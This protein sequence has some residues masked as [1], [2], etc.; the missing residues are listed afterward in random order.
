[1]L[2]TLINWDRELFLW[3]NGQGHP[4]LDDVML[5]LSA[6]LVWAPL[7]LGL[8]YLLY[9][10]YGWS[11]WKPLVAVLVAV[12]LADQITSGFMKPYFE[13]FRPCKD[14]TL[15]GLVINVGKCGAKYG[16]ASSHAANTFALALFY[17][18]L[19]R[20]RWYWL[21]IAWAA[22]VSYSRV[23][24]GVHFPGDILVGGLIGG[25]LGYMMATL[26]KKYGKLST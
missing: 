8:I 22:L 13:R 18:S 15:E 16:F 6:K 3:L 21:L 10:A 25:L 20:I 17:F 9:R 12:A 1:M 4:Q 14:P 23:Y 19:F 24:L 5:F 11:F 7:Y 2:D 26:V